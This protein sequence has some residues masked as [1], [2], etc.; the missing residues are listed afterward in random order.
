MAC[1]NY[2][3]SSDSAVLAVRR[4]STLDLLG[5][6]AVF[7][8]GGNIGTRTRSAIFTDCIEQLRG[9]AGRRQVNVRAET[10]VAGCVLPPGY[11]HVVF[12]KYPT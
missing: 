5:A 11:G 3:R 2:W 9:T 1:P 7:S 6:V 8:S 12:G 10:A 4:L